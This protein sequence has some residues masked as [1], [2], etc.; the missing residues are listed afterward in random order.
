MVFL[1]EII[2]ASKSPRRHELLSMMGYAFTVQ[3]TASPEPPPSRELLPEENLKLITAAKGRET[4]LVNPDCAVI[5]ADTVVVLNGKYYGKPADENDAL[6]MLT[7]LSGKTHEVYTGVSV[8]HAAG[9]YTQFDFE[10]TPVT[11]KKLTKTVILDYIKTGEP[12]DKAGAYGIQGYGA[13]LIERVDG[14]FYNVMGLPVGLLR[15]ML[16]NLV[17]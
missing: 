12:M 7:E 9:G 8:F 11:F 6:R 14:D 15:A 2:L 16:F 17:G 13:K 10:R 1:V 5:A 4:A 3:V